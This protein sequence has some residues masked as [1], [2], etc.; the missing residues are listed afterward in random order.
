MSTVLKSIPNFEVSLAKLDWRKC[1][2]E[3]QLNVDSYIKSKDT[4]C[5]KSGD[6]EQHTQWQD[7]MQDIIELMF[8]DDK[9]PPTATVQEG[10]DDLKQKE[11]DLKVA[12]ELLRNRELLTW[13]QYKKH[14]SQNN[15]TKGRAQGV[16]DTENDLPHRH[17]KP[18]D[19]L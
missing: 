12:G 17:M 16:S 3:F 15:N 7:L 6:D 2:A 5:F 14:K 4:Q 11:E 18:R 8:P 13:N 10:V 9:L 1:Q 19:R